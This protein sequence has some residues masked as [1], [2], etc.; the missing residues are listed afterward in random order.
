MLFLTKTIGGR[1]SGSSGMIKAE[2]WGLEMLRKAGADTV[3]EQPVEVAHWI[4][5]GTDSAFISY[6]DKNGERIRKSI[7]VLSLGN[8]SGS[9]KNGVKS[10]LIRFSSF[11]EL[12]S[13]KAYV[14]GK[15]VFFNPRFKAE[16]NPIRE[17]SRLSGY[18]TRG[19]SAASAYGSKGVIVRSLTN[20]IDNFPHVGLQINDKNVP[21]IP[22]VA[23][24]TSDANL[25]DDLFDAGIMIDAEIYTYGKI[26]PDTTGHNLIGELKGGEFPDRYITIGAHLDS[27]DVGEGA[28]D[29]G[30]GAIITIELLRA[31]KESGYKPRNTIRFVLFADEENGIHG[32]NEY[33]KSAAAKNE[34]HLFAIESD[35]G[36][37]APFRFGTEGLSK[38]ADDRLE[39][40]SNLFTPYEGGDWLKIGAADIEP[41]H[42]LLKVPIAALWSDQQQY[43]KVHHSQ[44][45]TFEN[46]DISQIKNGAINV[47][48]M[49]YL[50]EKYDLK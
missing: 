4:R 40:F 33:A 47:A 23:I 11:G 37:F 28:S 21:L 19:P 41:L 2:Q 3:W 12:D 35:A 8:T 30:T 9:G 31:L 6:A 14:S 29:D 45:D 16:I 10:S 1:L 24:S 25:I 36:A 15:I 34:N 13:N 43:F 38:V 18:R 49:M 39:G 46:T 32:G 50:V 42:Q 20:S 27:W 17:Y 7:S 44:A 22:A 48:I 5:G 26:L